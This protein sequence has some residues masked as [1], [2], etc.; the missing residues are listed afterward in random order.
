MWKSKHPNVHSLLLLEKDT[1]SYPHTHRLWI[2]EK[3]HP[4][5][6]TAGGGK[7]SKF[8]KGCR[9]KVSLATSFFLVFG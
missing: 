8:W 2:L 7:V 9:K 3:K 4:H 6:H 1:P 5:I